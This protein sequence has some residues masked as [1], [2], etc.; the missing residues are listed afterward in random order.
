[1]NKEGKNYNYETKCRRCGKLTKWRFSI[2]DKITWGQFAEAMQDYIEHPRQ[3]K[4]NTCEKQTVQ[5]VVS[6]SPV[7][8]E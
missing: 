4:C 7:F 8:R 2:L 5:D 1:M 6:Y 3:N